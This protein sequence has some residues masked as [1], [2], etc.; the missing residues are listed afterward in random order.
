MLKGA[1]KK[2]LLVI[3]RSA[4]PPL[5]HALRKQLIN[6]LISFKEKAANT[7]TVYDDLFIDFLIQIVRG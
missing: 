2:L 7:G 4:L 6:L 3:V 5:S 1:F